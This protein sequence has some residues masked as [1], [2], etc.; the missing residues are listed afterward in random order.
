VNAGNGAPGYHAEVRAMNEI[1]SKYPEIDPG[2][3]SVSTMLLQPKYEVGYFSACTNCSNILDGFD[4]I[5]G[6]VIDD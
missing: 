4:I 1:Y 6:A 2:S 5:T 3:V